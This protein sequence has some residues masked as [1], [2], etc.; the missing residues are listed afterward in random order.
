MDATQTKS[1]TEEKHWFFGRSYQKSK[2]IQLIIASICI[3]LFAL[4][5]AFYIMTVYDRV[6]PNEGTD[7]YFSSRGNDYCHIF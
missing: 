3:N 1:A 5:S 2:L 4:L 6:I 7:L